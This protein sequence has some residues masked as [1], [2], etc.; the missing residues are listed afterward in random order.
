MA[1]PAIGMEPLECNPLDS[2]LRW[3]VHS[4]TNASVTYLV[5]L[6]ENEQFGWCSC[7]HH[8]FRIQPELDRNRMPRAPRC[9]HINAAHLA[10]AK[11]V[12][13]KMSQQKS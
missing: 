7:D 6:E 9:K 3:N 11:L 13:A 10:L 5:D 12:V 2:Y 1:A 4:A 8:R